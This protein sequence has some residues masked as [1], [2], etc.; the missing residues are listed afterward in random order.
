[1]TAQERHVVEEKIKTLK[2]E[3]EEVHG[4]K[5]EVYSRVCGYLRPVQ[6]YNKGKQEEFALRSKF[7][8]EQC[9]C[10]HAN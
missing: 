9:E 6:S 3:M 7:P 8:I 2:E 10:C 4:S 1:M 5:C